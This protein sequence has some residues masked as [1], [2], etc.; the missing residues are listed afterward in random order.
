MSVTLT[1]L[2]FAR[3]SELCGGNRSDTFTFD[4][5][6]GDACTVGALKRAVAERYPRAAGLLGA[7]LVALNHEYVD[8]DARALTATDE[9]AIIPPIS[10]G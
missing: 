9:V 8:D 3:M 5:A 2:F 4:S 1:V 7:S 6:A 10:G